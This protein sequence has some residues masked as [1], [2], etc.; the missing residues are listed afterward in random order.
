MPHKAKPKTKRAKKRKVAKVLREAKAG[1]LRT[2]AGKK[3]VSREQEVAI[4]LNEA[5]VKRKGRKSK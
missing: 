5:G 2:S 1:T 3:P 4:A